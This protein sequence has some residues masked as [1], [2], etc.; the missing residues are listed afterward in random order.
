M[1]P[2]T[3]NLS[4]CPVHVWPSRVVIIKMIACRT[5]A[6]LREVNDSLLHLGGRTGLASL[7]QSGVLPVSV[8]GLMERHLWSVLVDRQTGCL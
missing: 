6:V 2:M 7:W 8:Q 1:F 4:L 5:N 3:T